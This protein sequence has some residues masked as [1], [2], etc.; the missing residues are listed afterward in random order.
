M[1]IKTVLKIEEP[2]QRAVELCPRCMG[3]GWYWS[4]LNFGDFPGDETKITCRDC[5]G[6]GRVT[7]LKMEVEAVVP[8]DYKLS[9]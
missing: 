4:D 7:T 5:N 2:K 3:N 9:A 8:F 6:S 1:Q